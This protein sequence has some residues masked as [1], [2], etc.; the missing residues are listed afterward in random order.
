MD[1]G[2]NIGYYTLLMA[3]AVQ[4]NGIVNSFEPVKKFREQLMWHIN[5]NNLQNNVKIFPFGLSNKN[6]YLEIMIDNPS[7]TLHPLSFNISN[8]SESIILKPLDEV[9][10]ELG[11]ENIDFIKIGIDGYELQF[12]K[13]AARTLKRFHHPIAMEFAQHCL[14]V[15]GSDVREQAQLLNDL[16]YSICKEKK[17]LSPMHQ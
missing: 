5:A 10:D 15:A 12:L 17:L 4:P 16:G 1:I 13:G 6:E 11:L 8:R 3:R 9:V 14:H 7:A 2:A